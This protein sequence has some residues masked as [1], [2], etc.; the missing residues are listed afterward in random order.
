MWRSVTASLD[1]VPGFVY[2][3][4]LFHMIPHI[5]WETPVSCFDSFECP[6]EEQWANG[7]RMSAEAKNRV[8]NTI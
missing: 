5:V 1:S 3:R 4:L 6:F 2:I 7:Q 8:G